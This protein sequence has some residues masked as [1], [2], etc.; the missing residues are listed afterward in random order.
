M[1]PAQL[2]IDLSALDRL[3]RDL[4][5]YWNAY[6][7]GLVNTIDHQV[8]L[9]QNVYAVE[10]FIIT[11]LRRNLVPVSISSNQ[12]PGVASPSIGTFSSQGTQKPSIG[13]GSFN[14]NIFGQKGLALNICMYLGC[15]GKSPRVKLF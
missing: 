15:A 6:L 11:V 2:A 7:A 12:K 13:N 9:C 4:L 14:N 10:Q 3:V 8:A 1:R 5:N